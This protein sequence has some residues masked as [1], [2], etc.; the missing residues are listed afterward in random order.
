MVHTTSKPYLTIS[1]V[2]DATGLSVHTLRYYERIGLMI[3]VERAESGHR[4]YSITAVEW[5]TLLRRLRDTGMP[6]AEM[7]RFSALLR[8]GDETVPSRLALLKRHRESIEQQIA[9]LQDTLE[10]VDAKIAA[11]SEGNATAPSRV[12]HQM[13]QAG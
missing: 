9:H 7:K 2:S 8:S 6:I 11:Y 5:L 1:E 3:P 12:E 13:E 10:V 4:R